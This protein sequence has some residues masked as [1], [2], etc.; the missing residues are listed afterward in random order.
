MSIASTPYR[1]LL[2]ALEPCPTLTAGI[3]LWETDMSLNLLKD[4]V[5]V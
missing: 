1:A 5:I 3:A 2:P 4:F